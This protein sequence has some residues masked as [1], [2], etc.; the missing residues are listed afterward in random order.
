MYMKID[1]I[2]ST[3]DSSTITIPPDKSRESGVSDFLVERKYGREMEETLVRTASNITYDL[4][5]T[6]NPMVTVRVI[7][8]DL[9]GD[10]ITG[11]GSGTLN[12]H[13]GTNERL[14]MRGRFDIE[15]GDYLFTFQSF[16]KKP[17]QIRKGTSNYITVER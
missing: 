15:E 13:S 2:A 1:A 14:T 7:L 4:D 16:F 10:E 8:D 11:R 5:V 9:T 17:F 3:T 6:A 12:I